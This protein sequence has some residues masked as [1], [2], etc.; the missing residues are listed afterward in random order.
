MR[1]HFSI[2]LLVLFVTFQQYFENV[3]ATVTYT[4]NPLATCGCSKYP[5]VLSKIVG[6]ETVK[7]NSWGWA[8]SLR[9]NGRHRCGATVISAFYMITAAHCLINI[10]SLSTVSVVVGI[11]TLS[12]VGQTRMI[13]KSHIHPQYNS[14]TF[15][16]DIAI[17]KLS[18]SLDMTDSLVSKI[19]L[20]II[21]P[22]LLTTQDYP[23][24]GTDLVAVG[25][26]ALTSDSQMASSTLQQVT[27]QAISKTATTC[28]T[29][30][31]NSALQFCA[32]VAGG[33]KGT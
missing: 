32:G 20:P 15:E 13:S 8:V 22:N 12:Q 3:Q 23:A 16:N 14:I 27:V 26:G 29:I 25:W 2:L 5:A 33:G 4:C 9:V 24:I 11:N 19:C 7:T 1:V 31:R 30:L 10:P 18:T 6:G 21:D 28:K 17:I